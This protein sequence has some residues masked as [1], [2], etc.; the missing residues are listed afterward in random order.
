MRA[1]PEAILLAAN[2]KLM[3]WH[4]GADAYTPLGAAALAWL[5]GADVPTPDDA[6]VLRLA[7][8]GGGGLGEALPLPEVV[9]W[10]EV[11]DPAVLDAAHGI[12]DRL[13]LFPWLG[14]WHLWASERPRAALPPGFLPLLARFNAGAIP[15][16][17]VKAWPDPTQARAVLS[18][19]IAD[20][21]L[22]AQAEG[23]RRAKALLARAQVE[24]AL[25]A[26]EPA[27]QSVAASQWPSP[28]RSREY[29]RGRRVPVY[30]IQSGISRSSIWHPDGVRA[31][32]GRSNYLPLALGM[33][34]A[35][36]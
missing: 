15:A 35:H 27:A 23:R 16:H 31:K 20:G 2:G 24:G 22:V 26:A 5:D 7:R 12:G 3:G 18:G 32:W 21:A 9:P 8:G 25:I 6:A 4:P 19:L 14:G 36:L 10:A 29:S 34:L 30:C 13:A 33:I 11:T 28:K 1:R 17:L